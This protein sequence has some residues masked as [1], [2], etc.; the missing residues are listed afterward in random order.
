MS[1]I[2][3]GLFQ[4]SQLEITAGSGEAPVHTA[5]WPWATSET[6]TVNNSVAD[7]AG[8]AGLEVEVFLPGGPDITLRASDFD[9]RRNLTY[10]PILIGRD[11]G[12]ARIFARLRRHRTVVAAGSISWILGDRAR[13]QVMVVRHAHPGYADENLNCGALC[14]EAARFPISEDARNYPAES[15]WLIVRHLDGWEG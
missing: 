6:V 8:L 7:S 11:S 1:L 5:K 9:G 3:C 2:G 12:E 15:L 4:D 13:W 14:V 10:G